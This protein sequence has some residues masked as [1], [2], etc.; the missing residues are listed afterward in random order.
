MGALLLLSWSV[1]AGLIQDHG[2]LV[3]TQRA[4]TPFP[5]EEALQGE[6][7]MGPGKGPAGCAPDSREGQLEP[8]APCHP[9]HS[10]HSWGPLS[11]LA[12]LH[13]LGPL[14][15][16]GLPKPGRCCGKRQLGAS[17]SLSLPPAGGSSPVPL[18]RRPLHGD[19]LPQVSRPPPGLPGA[20]LPRGPRCSLPGP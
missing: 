2:L 14:P 11:S 3:H 10:G 18:M 16:R 20:P 5:G 17:V 6:G 7:G 8:R 15:S 4:W 13:C 9:P 12:G 19:P 1:G